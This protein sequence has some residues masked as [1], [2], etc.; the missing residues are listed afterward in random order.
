MSILFSGGAKGADSLFGQCAE[1]VEH[2]VTHYAFGGMKSTCIC[3]VLNALQLLQADTYLDEANKCLKRA[4]PT[5]SVY[6]NNLLRRNYYQI[7]DSERIY[8]V[9]SI[10]KKSGWVEGGTGWAVCMGVLNGM[11]EVYVYDVNL[12]YWNRFLEYKKVKNKVFWEPK[13]NPP[14][15]YGKYT[16]IGKVELPEN[17]K[18]AIKALYK[19]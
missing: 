18:E 3:Y 1:K 19:V 15:P 12:G 11:N 13:I 4:Y 2:S 9:S 5:R 10:D 6:V 16:G 8:A 17:G 7:E 14:F